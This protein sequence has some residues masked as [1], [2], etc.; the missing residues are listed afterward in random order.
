LGGIS[1][2]KR[3]NKTLTNVRWSREISGH[4]ATKVVKDIKKRRD[5]GEEGRDVVLPSFVFFSFFAP[6]PSSC[7]TQEK[8]KKQVP[9]LL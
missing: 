6:S 9:S 4:I 8:K 7:I 3:T 1:Q 2:T 5:R